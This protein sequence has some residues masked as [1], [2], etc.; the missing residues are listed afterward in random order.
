MSSGNRARSSAPG[1]PQ[2]LHFRILSEHESDP[3]RR[4]TGTSERPGFRRTAPVTCASSRRQS[5]SFA[6][7]K[8]IVESSNS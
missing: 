1:S 7:E 5:P 8:A 3:L 4:S 6:P 2:T